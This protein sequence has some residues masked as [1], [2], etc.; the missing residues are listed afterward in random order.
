MKTWIKTAD[1]LPKNR[2]RVLVCRFTKNNPTPAGDEIAIDDSLYFDEEHM[3]G[4]GK[5]QEGEDMFIDVICWRYIDED[6][7]EEVLRSEGIID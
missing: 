3:K 5:V 7:L 4:F 1:G 6:G 2:S